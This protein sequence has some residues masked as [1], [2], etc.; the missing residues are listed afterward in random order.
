LKKI[1][2][3]FL[4]FFSLSIILFSQ[5]FEHASISLAGLDFNLKVT[6]LAD[7]ISSINI[8]IEK[9]DQIIRRV[10]EVDKGIAEGKINIEE[11]GKYTLRFENNDIS[12]SIRILPGWTSLLPPLLAIILALIIRQV[13]VALAAGSYLGAIFLYDFDPFTALLR[14]ADTIV[15]NGLLDKDHVYITLFTLLI[16]GVVG[17]ISKNGGTA[18]LARIITKFARTVK[19]TLI[20]SWLLGILIFFDDYA[21]SLIIGNLM[22]PITDRVK[23]SREKLS[24]IVDSTAAPVASL[25][26]ISTWIGYQVGLI[27][28]GL[29]AVGST[30]NAY[31]IFLHSIPYGFYT[32]A[33]LFF[34]FLTSVTGRDFGPMYKA[35]YRARTT[36]EVTAKDTNMKEIEGEKDLFS[37]DNPKWY[38]GALPIFVILFG[39][40]GGLIFT[41][42]QSL[43][44]QG[45]VDYSV[46]DIISNGDSY[47]ALLWSSFLAC[48]VAVVMTVTQKILTLQ[49]AMDAWQDGLRSM[50]IAVIILVFAWSI[51]SV[52][53]E[54]RTAD[55][56]ISI[57]S[58]A[59][60]PMFLPILVFIVCSVICFSTGTSWGTMAI[61]IPIVIPLTFKLCA[62]SGLSYE[63]TNTLLYAVVSSVLAGSVFGDHC[64]PISDT[65]ILSS[66]ASRC[67]HI[68]H[69]QTQLPYAIVVG[70]ACIIFGYLPAGFGFNPIISNLLIFASLIAFLMFFGKKVPESIFQVED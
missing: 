46:Q 64:S 12:S 35:E 57:L 32:I 3:A 41:G 27:N 69:V 37:Q 45:I 38:N 47:A 23:I 6:G 34:V 39:T 36:G 28:D 51:S 22:R 48:V 60:E 61:V 59:V 14:F 40:I 4:A 9:D 21:N 62:A 68:D 70:V 33:A 58:G 20:S 19:S 11:S 30:Q 49:K 66:M 52:T 8:L 24:Y 44:S 43:Q 29:K 54:L 55:Y 56:L 50:M 16:G 15:L 10:I 42:M 5:S 31:E 63:E 67:N 17:V 7:S 26:I 25:I 1:K 13:V 2:L 65:T 53:T 18:G